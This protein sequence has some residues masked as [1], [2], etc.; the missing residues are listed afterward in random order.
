MALERELAYF[1]AQKED[2]LSKYRGQFALIY[3]EEL[4]GTYTRFEDAF[5]AGVE[6]LGNQ[7]FLVQPIVEN[8][9]Q[10]QFPALAVGMLHA[11]F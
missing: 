1:E 6:R 9:E 4:L 3:G 8:T 10:V 5:E 2:L 11:R 7:S